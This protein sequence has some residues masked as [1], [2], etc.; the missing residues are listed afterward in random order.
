MIRSAPGRPSSSTA[1]IADATGIPVEDV[2]R[3]IGTKD[4]IVL[5]VAEDMLAP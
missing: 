2:V 3:T 5:K 4:A 1:Q